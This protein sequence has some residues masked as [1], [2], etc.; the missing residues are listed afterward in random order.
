[1]KKQ[2]FFDKKAV[3]LSF[4]LNI[5]LLKHTQGNKGEQKTH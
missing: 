2:I 4:S 3:F 1:M 5:L